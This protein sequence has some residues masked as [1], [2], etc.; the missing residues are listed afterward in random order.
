MDLFL[1]GVFKNHFV[2]PGRILVENA[3][4]IFDGLLGIVEFGSV[5]KNLFFDLFEN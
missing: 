3:P 1:R 5:L 2:H 4:E